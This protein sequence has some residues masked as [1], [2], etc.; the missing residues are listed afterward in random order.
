M[1]SWP[2]TIKIPG[3]PQGKERPRL[4][5]GHVYTP[6]STKSYE[7]LIGTLANVA[8]R[9]HEILTGPV[10]VVMSFQFGSK[11]GGFYIGKADLDNL[12]KS[13]LDGMNGIVFKDDRQVCQLAATKVCGP[14]D[15]AL[16]TV[17]PVP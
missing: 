12:V 16:V 5:K 10:S 9:G 4:G 8:M 11:E 3:K 17:G 1:S 13:C 14:E 15:I 2:I 7:T 6:S